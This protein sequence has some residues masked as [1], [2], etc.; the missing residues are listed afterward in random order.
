MFQTGRIEFTV[1]DFVILNLLAP[2]LF[3]IS[4]FG[5]RILIRGQAEVERLERFEP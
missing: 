2:G 5:F 4:C 1:L 3:R